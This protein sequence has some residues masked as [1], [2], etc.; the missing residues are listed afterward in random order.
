LFEL[1]RNLIVHPWRKTVGS[2]PEFVKPDMLQVKDCVL[3]LMSSTIETLRSVLIEE[4]LG[5]LRKD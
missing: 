2:E 4:M 3:Y 5:I 1:K